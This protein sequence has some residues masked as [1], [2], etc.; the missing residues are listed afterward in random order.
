MSGSAEQPTFGL[1]YDDVLLLP[2]YSS[3]R[4]RKDV[5]TKTRLSKNIMLNLPIVSANMD[6]V[7][8]SAMA[9]AIARLGGIGV[10]HRFLRWRTRSPR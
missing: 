1:T 6:T 9:I 5:D 3:I 7:T 10:I 8:E 2:K 4:S